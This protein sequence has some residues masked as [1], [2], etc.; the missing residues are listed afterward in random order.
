MAEVLGG[1]I[2]LI[3]LLVLVF[4]FF[5]FPIRAIL[6]RAGFNPALAW[7]LLAPG[8]GFILLLGLLGLAEWP[9]EREL[10]ETMK[11]GASHV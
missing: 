2:V 7:L 10:A 6:R 4:L 9:V 5:F 8:L 1:A 11:K 3:V